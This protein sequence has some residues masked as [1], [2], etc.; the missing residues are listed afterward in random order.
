[1]ATEPAHE[2]PFR[3]YPDD[4]NPGTTRSRNRGGAKNAGKR[5]AKPAPYPIRIARI[6]TVP[7]TPE[8]LDNAAEALAVLLN[9]FWR[10]HPDLA[11]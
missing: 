5:P 6:E 10:E 1:M 3:S 8:E 7:M 9:R 2:T 11:A 4:P